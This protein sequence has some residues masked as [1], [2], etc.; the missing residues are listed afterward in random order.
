MFSRFL[1]GDSA[2]AKGDLEKS[3]DIEPSFT[4]SWVK[5]ASVHMEQGDVA[6][7]FAAFEAAI[8]HNPKDPDIFYHR[9]Q[10]ESPNARQSSR[11]I[12]DHASYITVYFIMGR[13]A[14]AAENYK[15]STTLD[16]NFVFSHIQL[17]VA[18]YK[19]DSLANSMA[20]F[21]KT[22]K[23]FPHRSEPQNY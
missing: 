13:F 12:H 20:T 18:Q 17:A 4:Q 22:L 21:R 16:D 10:G 9:G 15:K 3:L 8:A 23:Q 19:S 14:E 2:G 11:F 7:A 1:V 6:N 5:V